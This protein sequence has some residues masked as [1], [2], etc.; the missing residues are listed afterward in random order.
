MQHDNYV[1]AAFIHIALR[2]AAGLFKAFRL[3]RIIRKRAFGQYAQLFAA[4][5]CICICHLFVFLLP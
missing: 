2:Q 3:K 4:E 5:I 1:T